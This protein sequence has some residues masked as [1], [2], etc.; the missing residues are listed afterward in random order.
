[1]NFSE[2]FDSVNIS[3]GDLNIDYS[4]KQFLNSIELYKDQD[5][6]EFNIE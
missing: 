3:E 1:M 2:Y 5:L 4:D 6:S